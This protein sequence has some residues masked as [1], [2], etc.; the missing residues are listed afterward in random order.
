MIT[1]KLSFMQNR[2]YQTV[3]RQFATTHTPIFCTFVWGTIWVAIFVR[4][5]LFWCLSWRQKIGKSLYF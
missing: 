1:S 3:N 2:Q 5:C 4:F